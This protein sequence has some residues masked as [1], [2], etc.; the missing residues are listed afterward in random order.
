MSPRP[1]AL[2]SQAGTGGGWGCGPPPHP[3]RPPLRYAPQ[4][5]AIQERLRDT[6]VFT[7]SLD[8]EN[9]ATSDYLEQFLLETRTGYCQQ[10]ATAFAVLARVLGF[11]TRVAVGFLPGETSPFHRQPGPLIEHAFALAGKRVVCGFRPDVMGK[12]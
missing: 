6:D 9:K 12:L 4:L 3:G 2:R 7:Y 10:Y 1:G 8:V 5:L 11:R